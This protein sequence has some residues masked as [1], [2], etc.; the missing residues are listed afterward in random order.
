MATPLFSGPKGL[1]LELH[2]ESMVNR[3]EAARFAAGE[4]T[5]VEMARNLDGSRPGT[6]A[7]KEDTVV[8]RSAPLIAGLVALTLVGAA[9]TSKGGASTPDAAAAQAK[10]DA[11]AAKSPGAILRS[12][13]D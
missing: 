6:V 10:I 7:G 3:F 11:A 12:T 9:C 5:C 13:L 8:R 1:C 4:E 2:S